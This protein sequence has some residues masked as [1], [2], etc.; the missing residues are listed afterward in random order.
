MFNLAWGHSVAVREAFV[1]YCKTTTIITPQSLMKYDYPAHEGEKALISLTADVILNTLGLTYKHIFITSG[2]TGGC[3]ISLRA[4]KQLGYT[5][6]FTRQPPFYVR[7][8]KMIEASGLEHTL[9]PLK[10]HSGTVAM[11]D[12]PSNPLGVMTTPSFI[13][14]PVILDA[15]Y[16]NQVYMN[17]IQVKHIPHDVLIGSYSK[18][19]GINGIRLGYMATNDDQLAAKMSELVTSEYC[20]LSMP[21]QDLLIDILPTFDWHQFYPYARYKLDLNREQFQRIEK[22][23][24]DTPVNPIGM[25]YYAPTDQKCK[26]IL[27][28]AG[29]QYVP[30]S[31]MGT[32]DAFGRFNLAQDNKL[33]EE[34]VR[35]ILKADRI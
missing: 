21:S 28:R 12:L 19:L 18:L 10:N 17:P 6:C 1:K 15:V 31:S 30:G 26:D 33:V 11:I 34:A 27:V 4:F 7:Y 14:L 29:V 3:V 16:L 32:T 5:H 9:N 13:G 25:F 35:A 23:F 20:G 2:A 22:F 24:Q 8:P